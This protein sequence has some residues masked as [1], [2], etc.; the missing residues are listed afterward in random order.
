MVRSRKEGR[1]GRGT[2]QQITVPNAASLPFLLA[3]FSLFFKRNFNLK[4]QLE[5]EEEES[6]QPARPASPHSAIQSNLTQ[7]LPYQS[8]QKF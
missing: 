5:E 2:Q 6:R 3:R 8:T 7:I 4:G 1:E